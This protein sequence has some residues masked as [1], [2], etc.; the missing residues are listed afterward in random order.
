M[1]KL[2]IT[3]SEDSQL[4]KEG[5]IHIKFEEA[6]KHI[7]ECEYCK[8]SLAHYLDTLELPFM[9]KAFYQQFLKTTEE[10]KQNG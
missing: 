10:K 9:F 8:V 5:E 3:L 7:S 1:G 6:V 2:A 4:E